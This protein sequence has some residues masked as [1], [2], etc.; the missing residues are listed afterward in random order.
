MPKCRGCQKDIR[1][2]KTAAGKYVPVDPEEVRF[3][4]GASGTDVFI[5][6][7]G[8]TERGWKITSESSAA[9]TGYT[10][11]FATCPY[12]DDFRNGRR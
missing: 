5:L 2:I 4:Q 6:P 12:A 3:I 1:F 9:K 10:A 8:S 7:D 11:H